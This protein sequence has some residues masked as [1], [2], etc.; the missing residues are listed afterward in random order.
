MQVFE[1]KPWVSRTVSV[2]LLGVLSFV[3]PAGGVVA[4]TNAT[5]VWHSCRP[6]NTVTA[7]SLWENNWKPFTKKQLPVLFRW[8]SQ[9]LPHTVHQY[10]HW[11]CPG[12][13]GSHRE[14]YWPERRRSHSLQQS[15]RACIRLDL[16]GNNTTTDDDSRWVL[17]S[18][19]H[20]DIQGRPVSP[21][22]LV[23]GLQV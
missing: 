22:T 21:S 4:F 9:A 19:Y 5:S 12:C 1:I 14:L 7:H 6:Q 8:C 17:M 23:Y 15:S 20:P 2:M 3:D 16:G 11:S 10:R 13:T 18:F